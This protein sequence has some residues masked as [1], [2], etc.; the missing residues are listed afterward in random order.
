MLTSKE[1]K[2]CP[3][4]NHAFFENLKMQPLTKQKIFNRSDILTEGWFPLCPAKSLQKKQAKSFT[5]LNQRIVLFRT[6]LGVL[7]ALDSFCPHMGADLGNGVVK[8]EK[9]QCLF[10][11]WKFETDG[12]LCLEDKKLHQLSFCKNNHYPVTEKY[13]FIWVFSGAQET[14]SLP[15]PPGLIGKEISAIHLK[16]VRLFA[17][18]HVMMASG[19]DLQHFK[20][21]HNID[22]K[23][24]FDIKSTEQDVFTF[25]LNGKIPQ[26]N[27]RGKIAKFLIGPEFSYQ[28]TFA[29]GTI[30]T[31]SYGEDV[32]VFKKFCCFPA[33]HI[34][35]GAIP[36]KLGVSDVEIFFIVEK[37]NFFKRCFSYL[38][39]ML[40][41]AVLRDDD[42]KAFPHMRFQVGKLVKGDEA[43]AKLIALINSLQVSSWTAVDEISH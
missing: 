8:G 25:K 38:L 23:F 4:D 35:W 13:G 43:V 33:I 12:E 11:G 6:E 36:T 39:T 1:I 28:I 17:H 30:A 10:H 15:Y 5:I 18:H 41:L 2:N 31:I 3:K 19:I 16:R 20:S 37:K 24:S 14:H 7:S 9:L 29:G 40:V 26:N 27:W 34:L 32:K 21:V 22:I 42:I